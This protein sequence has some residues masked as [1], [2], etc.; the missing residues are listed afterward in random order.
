M[1]FRRQNGYFDQVTALLLATGRFPLLADMHSRAVE[2]IDGVFVRALAR[3]LDGLHARPQ[4]G[5][6]SGQ[7]CP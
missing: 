2:D 1:R 5:S 4:R 3:N 6:D 7:R